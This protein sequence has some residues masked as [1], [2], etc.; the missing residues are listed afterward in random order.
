MSLVWEVE[1]QGGEVVFTGKTKKLQDTAYLRNKI[2]IDFNNA[3][4]LISVNANNI[5]NEN[6]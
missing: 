5:K 6:L 3:L 1:M 2:K 4:E